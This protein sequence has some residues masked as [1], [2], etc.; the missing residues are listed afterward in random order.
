MEQ[1]SLDEYL[2]DPSRKIITRDGKDVRIICTSMK[3]TEYPIVAAVTYDG[4][5]HCVEYTPEGKFRPFA[6]EYSEDLFFAPETHTGWINVY[7]T[8]NSATE[9]GP[10]IYDSKD[11]AELVKEFDPNYV[12]TIR[13]EWED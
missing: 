2:K 9:A 7:H 6:V 11:K 1:F 13:I 5:E 10:I 3:N 12:A 4:V 8:S